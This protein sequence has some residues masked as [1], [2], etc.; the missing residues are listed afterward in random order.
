MLTGILKDLFH[1]VTLSTKQWAKRRLTITDRP[2]TSAPKMFEEEAACRRT[3]ELMPNFAEAHNRLGVVLKDSK[4]LAEAEAAFRRAINLQ[5]DNVASHYNLGIVLAETNRPLEAEAAY[6]DALRL[7]PNFVEA[8]N[9]L[10]VVLLMAKRLTEAEAAFRRVLELAPDFVDA[11]KNLGIALAQIGRVTEAEVD[12]QRALDPRPRQVAAQHDLAAALANASGPWETEAAYRNVLELRPDFVEAR[13]GLGVVL[14]Q[15]KRFAEAEAAFRGALEL[16]PDF[17]DAHNNLGGILK[18]TGRLAEAEAAFRR[19]LI[20]SPNHEAARMNLDFVRREINRL[21]KAEAACRRAVELEPASAAPHYKLGLTLMSLGKLDESVVTFREVLSI[22]PLR[23]EAHDNLGVALMRKGQIDDA[24]ACHLQA[25][26]I[27]PDF[28]KAMA[29]LG[30][31]SFLKKETEQAMAWNKAALAIE[32][33]QVE[34]NQNMA[35]ILLERGDRNEAKRHLDRAHRKQSVDIEYAADPVR[36]VLLLWTRKKGNVPTIEFLFPTTI[37]NRVNW[38]IESEHDDQTDSLPDHD[39]VFNAMGDPDLIGDSSLPVSRFTE[40]CEKPL[41]NHPAKVARTARNHLPALLDG[42]GN[43]FVPRVW[44]FANRADWDESVVECL[45]LLIRPVDSHGGAGLELARTVTELAQYRASQSGPVYVCRFIDFR[46]ADSW[47]RKYR[48]IFIDR[49][50]YPCH[51]AISQNWMVHYYTADMESHPWKLEEEKAFLH[52]PEA[53]LGPV[54]MEAI[55]SIGARMDLE[56]SGIDFS[57]TQDERILV[58]E[59]NPTMLVHPESSGGPVEHKN[60]YVFRIQSR[61]E[62][63]LKRLCAQAREA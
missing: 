20:L 27:K 49:E 60:E 21:S 17:S 56:Y 54:N 34:A 31:A 2:P 19:A 25:I 24:V 38:V 7:Q 58:F 11:R 35:S 12:R 63:M 47:F 8:Y 4:R 43:V 28:A 18:D 52:D 55:R 3:L 33:E 53:V 32:P 40:R 9:N 42:L 57:I 22:E 29:H 59:A 51:L 50:P 16:E 62:V 44:R 26:S 10:G 14:A 48:I 1:A 45:P 46:S 30:A 6:R 15:T 61:F 39:L 13:N 5:R 36:T 41:L 23:A 37:N